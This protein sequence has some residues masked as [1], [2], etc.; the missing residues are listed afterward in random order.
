MTRFWNMKTIRAAKQH[1]PFVAKFVPYYARKGQLSGTLKRDLEFHAELLK[2][3]NR[4]EEAQTKLAE[5]AN[6]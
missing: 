5:A 3:M 2:R 6:L 1:I 4:P